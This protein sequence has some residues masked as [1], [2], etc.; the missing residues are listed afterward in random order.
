VVLNFK[1]SDLEVLEAVEPY[2]FPIAT[3][4]VGYAPPASSRGGTKFEA[5]AGSLRKLMPDNPDINLLKGKKQEWK[6]ENRSLRR[7]LTD[8]EGNPLMDGN[9]KQLW[10]EV[11]TLCWTVIAIEGLGSAKEADA[12]FNEFLVN[13]ADGKTEPKFYEEALQNSEVTSRPH[14]VDAIVKRTLLPN[15]KEMKLIERDAEGILH[16]VVAGTTPPADET[17]APTEATS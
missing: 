5:L 2:P 10:G 8:E 9:N 12:N 7:G 1:F 15:L 17:A 4:T 6:M 11:P 16:K 13:L 3:I 14:I